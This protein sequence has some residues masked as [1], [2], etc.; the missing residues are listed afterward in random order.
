VTAPVC[1][2]PPKEKADAI[3]DF[4]LPEESKE[5]MVPVQEKPVAEES[6]PE[7]AKK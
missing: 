7:P 6:A 2:A 1:P 4:P 5:D 3:P